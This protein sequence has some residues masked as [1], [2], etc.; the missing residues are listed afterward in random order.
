MESRVVIE[1]SAFAQIVRCVVN[2]NFL[3]FLLK[4]EQKMHRQ[5][6]QDQ[7]INKHPKENI[8]R[9]FQ[10]SSWKG[11]PCL[12]FKENMTSKTYNMWHIRYMTYHKTIY[13]VSYTEKNHWKPSFLLV[14][15]DEHRNTSKYFYR[16]Y[17]K[18]FLRKSSKRSRQKFRGRE[19]L[20]FSPTSEP[21]SWETTLQ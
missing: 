19:S 3:I 2:E 13:G 16:F 7:W 6:P 17:N 12:V 15:C 8:K 9:S 5:W 1:V 10:L 20:I 21:T 4:L 18:L 11:N 14:T